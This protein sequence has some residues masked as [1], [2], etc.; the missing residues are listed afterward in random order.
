MGPRS[1]SPHSKT[2]VNLQF[3]II[4]K[5]PDAGFKGFHGA[6]NEFISGCYYSQPCTKL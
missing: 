2:A 5:P 3:Q 6:G 1:A 4:Q